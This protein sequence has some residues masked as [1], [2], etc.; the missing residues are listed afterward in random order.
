MPASFRLTIWPR[1]FADQSGSEQTQCGLCAAQSFNA[2][3]AELRFRTQY[4][5][6]SIFQALQCRL[7]GMFAIPHLKQDVVYGF[8]ELRQWHGGCTSSFHQSR[9][10]SHCG[11]FGPC[12]VYNISREGADIVHQELHP[13]LQAGVLNMFGRDVHRLN[14]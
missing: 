13:L 1:V 12:R 10:D 14:R 5:A 9:Q 7:S 3:A 6:S 2:L 8:I 4:G 11:S